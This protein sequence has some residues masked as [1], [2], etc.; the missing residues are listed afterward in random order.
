MRRVEGYHYHRIEKVHRQRC[1]QMHRFISKLR[2]FPGCGAHIL[3]RILR[4]EHLVHPT[5]PEDSTPARLHWAI[6]LTSGE[7]SPMLSSPGSARRY[8]SR[9]ESTRQCPSTRR[10]QAIHFTPGEHLPMPSS[11]GTDRGYHLRPESTR[12]CS[13]RQAPSK[14]ITRLRRALANALSAPSVEITHI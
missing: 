4:P 3:A 10:C 13:L 7:Y 11:P 8:C 14:N 1:S 5:P 2:Y 12:Q 6:S 9:Q